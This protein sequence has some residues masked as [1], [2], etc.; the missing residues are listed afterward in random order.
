MAYSYCGSCSGVVVGGSSLPIIFLVSFVVV[1]VL[2]VVATVITAETAIAS[3]AATIRKCVA[4]TERGRIL[5]CKLPEKRPCFHFILA[6][7]VP[8]LD[9]IHQV[10]TYAKFLKDLCTRKR[11]TNIPKKAFLDA[12]VSS[13]LSS[14][15]PIKYKDPGAPIISCVIGETNIKKALLDLGA[16]V[17]ILPYLVY[18]QLGLGRPFLATANA[19]IN[20]RNG[21][22]KLSFGNMT[23]ELNVFNL[24]QESSSHADVNVVQD[25]IYESIDISDDE[26]DLESN[27]WLIHE[28]EDVNEILKEN[29]INQ[30]STLPTELP[31]EPIIEMVKSSPK[32]SIKEAPILELKPLPEHLKYAYLEPKETL[33]V[34]IASD[35]DP[36]QEDGYSGYNQI[37]IAAED[38]EKTTFTCP[39]GTFAYRRMPF[40]LCNAPATFQRCM[41]SMFSDMI[42]RF[43][44]IF[45]DDFSVFGLTFSECLNHLQLV[46]ERDHLAIRHLLA[47]KDAKAR[48]ACGGH[49]A[50]KKTAAKVLQCDF[51]WPNLFKDAHE[52]CK[53]C[54]QC[55]KM[56]R[57]T[58]RHMMPL[59]PILVV[60]VFDVWGIDFM[61]PF[62]NSFGNEYILVAVDYVSKWGEAIVCRTPDSKM[63]IKFLKE[64]IL[65]RFG[66]P[67]AIISDRGTHFCNRPFATLMKKYN[68]THKLATPYH[69]QTSGQVEV[70][71]RQIKQILKKTVSANRKDWSLKL[72]D[73][74]WAYRTA[75]KTNLGM[76][77]YR[78]VF[79]LLKCY[80]VIALEQAPFHSLIRL[81]TK[82]PRNVWRSLALEQAPF[83]SLIRLCTKPPR[84]VWR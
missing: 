81:C 25:G 31:T 12:S 73:A 45:M 17:N 62:P 21:L 43:L 71:N 28:S 54:A 79:G 34:I 47:K 7:Y 80:Q 20:C 50:S 46:L 78:I 82:P 24:E 58:K 70:S 23:I 68:V 26:V 44:K 30:E 13:Y 53:S 66:I 74:L 83:H 10:P 32:P 15:V 11:T 22:M 60:E 51:Y 4:Q 84:N 3:V 49:F 64:N 42:E 9:I 77:P 8:P 6:G 18:E 65:S 59:N 29:Q 37:P 63:V 75:F 36:K 61:G 56:G 40:G 41:I 48:L 19:E 76:S 38:Q 2:F 16:S 69:P 1:V 72:I 14:H 55:Q 52:Y 57:I 5:C 67:R 27:P 39:F 35:L 33:P